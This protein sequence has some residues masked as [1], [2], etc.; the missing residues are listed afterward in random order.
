MYESWYLDQYDQYNDLF[1]EDFDIFGLEIQ[2]TDTRLGQLQSLHAEKVLDWIKNTQNTP[3]GPGSRQLRLLYVP[4]FEFER[5]ACSLYS[6]LL[7]IRD[8]TT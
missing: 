2:G 7:V 5:F 3:L 1:H 4:D 6:G 8:I